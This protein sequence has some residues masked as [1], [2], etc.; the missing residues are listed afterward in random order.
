MSTS[1]IRQSLPGQHAVSAELALEHQTLLV[2]SL[3]TTQRSQQS[4][5]GMSYM[6]ITEVNP[7]Q[8]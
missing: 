3:S 7:A 2:L 4:H 8:M 5:G 1:N 6:E